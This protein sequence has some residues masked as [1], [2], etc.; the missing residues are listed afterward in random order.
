MLGAL[1]NVSLEALGGAK[2]HL[3]DDGPV[4]LSFWLD[5]RQKGLVLDRDEPLVLLVKITV[6][7]R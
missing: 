5:C 6:E 2:G 3:L 4:Q 1:S 7:G